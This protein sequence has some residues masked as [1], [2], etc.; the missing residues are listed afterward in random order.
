MTPKPMWRPQVQKREGD[1]PTIAGPQATRFKV[2]PP[3]KRPEPDHNLWDRSLRKN[4]TVKV[5][6]LTGDM[7]VGSVVEFGLNSVAIKT[8][9]GDV[10]VVFKSAIAAARSIHAPAY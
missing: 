1:I 10:I 7:V 5:A 9:E 8:A 6:L 2:E 3:R 4:L